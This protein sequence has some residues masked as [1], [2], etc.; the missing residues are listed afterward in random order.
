[1]I[2]KAKENEKIQ[3]AGNAFSKAGTFTKETGSKVKDKLD[4]TGVTEVA[5]NV[6]SKLKAGGLLV[7]NFLYEKA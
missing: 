2:H 6:G 3:N 1:M 5:V 4:E 7:G